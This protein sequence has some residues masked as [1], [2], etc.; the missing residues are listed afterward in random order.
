MDDVDD[1]LTSLDFPM[2]VKHFNSYSSI[3][4]VKESKV[5]NAEAL[6]EQVG[7][8]LKEYGGCLVEEYIA[9]REFCILVSENP[10]D[11]SSPTAF[12]PV[13]CA[14]PDGEEFKHFNLKWFEYEGMEWRLVGDRD[15]AERLKEMGRQI[16]VG[17]R[18]RGYGRLDVRSDPTGRDLYFLEINPNCGVFYPP[19]SF[20]SADQIL[21]LDPTTSHASFLA[22]QIACALRHHQDK[23][24][25]YQSLWRKGRGFGLFATRALGAGDTVQVN[26]GQPTVVVSRQHVQTT[27][28]REAMRDF[29]AY[30]WPL[31]RGVFVTWSGDPTQWAPIN[32]SCD[33]NTWLDG[34]LN[35]VARRPIQSG[36]ELTIDYA[37][38]CVESGRVGSLPPVRF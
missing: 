3:G 2:I 11:P 26:E 38:F 12:A 7:R 35:T 1:V 34:G 30:A 14:F 37:T 15:L 20:G 10:N 33:P 31:G 28:P 29:E 21:E 13:E 23:Q 27:W 32:H 8:M 22:D 17:M 16:F 9:N 24:P 4:M 36:E 19:G 25:R 5:S 6:R 18:G